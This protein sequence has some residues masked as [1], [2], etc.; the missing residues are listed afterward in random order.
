MKDQAGSVVRPDQQ[1]QRAMSSLSA[2]GIDRDTEFAEFFLNFRLSAVLSNQNIELLDLCSPTEQILGATE[3]ARDIYEMPSEFIC[4]TSG[5]G[6][7][8]I[9]YSKRDGKIYD[10]GVDEIDD[11]DNGITAARWDSFYELI[12]WYLS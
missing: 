11:L 10:I 12:E 3:F 5:E 6:E 8:F 7:G 9:V 4:L 2:L 1:F